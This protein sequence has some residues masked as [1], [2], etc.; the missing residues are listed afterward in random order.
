M[1]ISPAVRLRKSSEGKIDF[2]SKLSLIMLPV[3]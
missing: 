3:F 2:T 1:T